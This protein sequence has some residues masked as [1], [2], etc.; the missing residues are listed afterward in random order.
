MSRFSLTL[1]LTTLA[2]LAACGAGGQGGGAAAAAEPASAAETAEAVFAG[3]CFWC[4]EHAFDEVDG[5]LSTTS[6]YIG[7]RV[8]RPTYKQVSAGGTG[9]AEAVKVVFDP[10]RVSYEE[11]LYAF[12]RNV[13]P[14]AEGRQFCDVGDQYRAEIFYLDD[15]QRRL[16]EA[17]KRELEVSKRFD[18]PIAVAV[19]AATEFY[20][21]EEYH[22]DYH[23]KN[24]IRYRFYRTGCGR[25]RR[26]QD[27]WGDEAGGH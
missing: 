5:V 26:L 3:G 16:A 7:G 8:A 17:S 23:Q 24:P 25:D 4:V 11:L 15:E 9:H 13:D 18:R 22:Q 10:S 2:L 1:T 19:T 6:G 14:L 12:W 20:P 27:V 21:A